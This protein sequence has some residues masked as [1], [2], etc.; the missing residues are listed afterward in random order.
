MSVQIDELNTTVDAR[1]TATG[2]ADRDAGAAAEGAAEVRLEELR[3]LVRAL[4]V[5]RA[6]G[7]SGVRAGCRGGPSACFP[8]LL[9]VGVGGST[10]NYL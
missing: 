7:G 1:G 10:L 3:P 4:V 9:R 8:R 2:A 5:A 6:C